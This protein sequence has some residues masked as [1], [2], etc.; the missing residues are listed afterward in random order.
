VLATG[1]I[2]SENHLLCYYDGKYMLVISFK[3]LQLSGLAFSLL[4]LW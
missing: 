3:E 1:I 2:R 4:T